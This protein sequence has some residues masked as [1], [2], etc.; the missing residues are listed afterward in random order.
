LFEKNCFELTKAAKKMNADGGGGKS[1]NLIHKPIAEKQSS[2][3]HWIGC[4]RFK[5][6][7]TQYDHRP[8]F[9]S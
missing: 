3:I 7:F 8:T 9:L 1:R 4:R 5:K 6:P 2:F